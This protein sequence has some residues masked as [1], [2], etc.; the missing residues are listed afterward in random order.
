MLFNTDPHWILFLP[1]PPFPLELSS[2]PRVALYLH[3]NWNLAPQAFMCN[4]LEIFLLFH[5]L[6]LPPS[7]HCSNVLGQ[8]PCTWAISGTLEWWVLNLATRYPLPSASVASPAPAN[9]GSRWFAEWTGLPHPWRCIILAL[10]FYISVLGCL[11]HFTVEDMFRVLT[12]SCMGKVI[13]VR[14]H[15]RL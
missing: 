2:F 11:M 9:P 6:P 10:L 13:K 12:P 5:T 4:Y 7:G 1:Q 8:E 3:L 15:P 14:S